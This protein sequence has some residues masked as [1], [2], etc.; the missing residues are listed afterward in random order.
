MYSQSEVLDAWRKATGTRSDGVL[1]LSLGKAR[2]ALSPYRRGT[3]VMDDEMG[4]LAADATGL[5]PVL[6]ILSLQGARA[7]L[8]GQKRLHKIYADAFFHCSRLGRM[9]LSMTKAIGEM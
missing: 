3:R 2:T 9:A 7:E 5:D 4:L 8:D 1:A 6:V